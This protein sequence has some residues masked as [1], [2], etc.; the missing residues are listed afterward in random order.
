MKDNQ[1][2]LGFLLARTSKA[3]SVHLNKLLQEER[4]D[5]PHSQYLVLRL[6]YLEDGISQQELAE[7]AFKDTAAVKRTLDILEGKG[8]IKRTPAP[9]NMKK[10]SVIITPVGRELMPRVISYLENSKNSYL[11][12]ISDEEYN[13][14]IRVLEKLY[15]NIS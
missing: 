7:R 9:A 13:A 3:M 12:G 1:H 6:L 10:N 15:Q 8:L 4:I 14:V 5:L 11:A 2:T